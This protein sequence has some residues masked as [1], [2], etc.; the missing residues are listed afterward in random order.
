MDT[1]LKETAKAIK[2]AAKATG[3]GIDATREFGSFIATYI[4][5]PLESG[6]GILAD[7]LSY[8]RWERQQRLMRKAQEYLE[9]N[10]VQEPTRP[11]PMKT[12]IPILQGASLED[13]DEIQDRWAKLLV[14]AADSESNITISRTYITVLEHLEPYNAAILDKI[15]SVSPED[16]K[17][18]IWTKNLPDSVILNPCENDDMS[19][20]PQLELALSELLQLRLISGALFW[21]GGVG[22]TCVYQTALGHSF[23]DACRIRAEK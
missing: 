12:L 7:K 23:L 17:E 2:E 16:A 3:K 6:L 13:S 9:A 4:H 15:Y 22:V 10:G 8:M 19:L 11:V 14:N 20:S 1:E 5:G 18:G 21:S